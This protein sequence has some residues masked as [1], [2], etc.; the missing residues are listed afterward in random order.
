MRDQ[1]KT[2]DFLL[3]YIVILEDPDR[4]E[5]YMDD[6]EESRSVINTNKST[7]RETPEDWK[8]TDDVDLGGMLELNDKAKNMI[9]SQR[10][11]TK[12]YESAV[13]DDDSISS[14]EQKKS[15]YSKFSKNKF[16][17]LNQKLNK[18]NNTKLRDYRNTYLPETP[19]NKSSPTK[20][21]DKNS[22]SSSFLMEIPDRVIK[23]KK[24]NSSETDLGREKRRRRNA[25]DENDV[26]FCGIAEST[27]K[28]ESRTKAT[29]SS[30]SSETVI[31]GFESLKAVNSRV[32]C[33]MSRIFLFMLKKNHVYEKVK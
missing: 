17:N 6:T 3:T 29:G 30:H 26:Y 18:I 9:L 13:E 31:S 27:F 12:V 33:K 23:E 32:L 5:K 24:N 14:L 11:K 7:A 10:R 1:W 22:S 28:S 20:Y 2:Y 21:C 19:F 25:R 15:I 4:F 16:R 8:N